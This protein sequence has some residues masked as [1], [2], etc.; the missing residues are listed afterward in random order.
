MDK[1]EEYFFGAI[2]FYLN[3]LIFVEREDAC[4]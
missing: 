4:C 3:L 1:W 2:S